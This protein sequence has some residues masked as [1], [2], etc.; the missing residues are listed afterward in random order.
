MGA[1]EGGVDGILDGFTEGSLEGVRVVGISVRGNGVIVVEQ[2][3]QHL[4]SEDR[5][6]LPPSYISPV[7]AGVILWQ[8]VDSQ[9]MQHPPPS[10]LHIFP[11]R[12]KS[13]NV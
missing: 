12:S 13:P 3:R 9:T 4:F 7:Q 2:S 5:Q 10:A 11:P 1:S 8:H 6:T